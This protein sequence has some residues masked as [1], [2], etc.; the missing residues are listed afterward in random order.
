[1]DNG[2]T[3]VGQTF[4][5]RTTAKE[6][7]VNSVRLYERRFEDRKSGKLRQ[8]FSL[9]VPTDIG[10][11]LKE[12]DIEAFNVELTEDGILYRPYGRVL[13]GWLKED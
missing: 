12:K 8:T 10:R 11:I 13:P 9:N 1:L 3:T 7:L 4:D 5:E 6:R 2:R